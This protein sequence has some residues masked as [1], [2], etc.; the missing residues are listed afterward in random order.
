M[1]KTLILYSTTDGQALRICERIQEQLEQQDNQI[2]MHEISE[3]NAEDLG[4]FD[5]VLIGASIRYGKHNKWVHKFIRENKARLEAMPTAFFTVNAVAR[6][7][8]KNTPDTNPYIIKFLR[9]VDWAPTLKGVF[10]GRIIYPKY[11]PFDRHIIRFIM[12]MTKGPTDLSGTFEFTK[13]DK[14][15]EFAEDFNKL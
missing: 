1:A 7:E 5:K 10:S 9:K 12:W 4:N 11:G 14:V 8:E 6:K 13:W 2:E 15:E 3:F